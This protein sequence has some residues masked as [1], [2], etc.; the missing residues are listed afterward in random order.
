MKTPKTDIA[1]KARRPAKRA[2]VDDEA[3]FTPANR[4]RDDEQ[5]FVKPENRIGSMK[6]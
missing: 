6:H 4:S 5:R 2:K 1:A 3:K